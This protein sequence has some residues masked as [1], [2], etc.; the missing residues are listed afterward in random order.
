MLIIFEGPGYSGKTHNSEKLERFF[1]NRNREVKR[2][3]GITELDKSNLINIINDNGFDDICI[4]ATLKSHIN[5]GIHIEGKLIYPDVVFQMDP[6]NDKVRVVG[7][8]NLDSDEL[9]GALL[10]P[11][12]KHL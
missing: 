2:Y 4:V 8:R 12:N 9:L 5:D 6:D 11:D 10:L 7:K 1:T 3:D